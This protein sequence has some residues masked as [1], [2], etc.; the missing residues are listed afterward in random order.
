MVSLAIEKLKP[1]PLQ[2]YNYKSMMRPIVEYASPAWNPYTDRNFSKL[3]QVQR[4]AARF[5]TNIYDPLS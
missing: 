5:V 3:E 4:N 2:V 1:T